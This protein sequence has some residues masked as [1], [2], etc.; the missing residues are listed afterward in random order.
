MMP[1]AFCAVI[2]GGCIAQTITISGR[3]KDTSGEGISGALVKLEQANISTTTGADGSFTLTG[4]AAIG[5]SGGSYKPSDGYMIRLSGMSLL[6]TFKERSNVLIEIFHTN[7]R[8]IL[9][10]RRMGNAGNHV[11]PLPQLSPGIYLIRITLGTDRYCFTGIPLNRPIFHSKWSRGISHSGGLSDR[12]A[13]VS[14]HFDDVL[15]VT[16]EGLLTHRIAVRN[17]DARG[18]DITMLHNAGDVADA[19]GN[20][21]QSVRIGNQVW[22]AENLKTTK[23]NDGTAITTVPDSATW[24]NIYLNALT[25]DA[26]CVYGGGAA[27]GAKYGV[28]YNWYAVGTGK[29]APKGWRVPTDTDWDTLQNYLIAHGYNYDGTTTGNQIAKSMAA[30]WGWDSSTIEGAVGNDLSTNNASGFSALPGGLRHWGGGYYSLFLERKLTYW[31]SSTE[32]DSVRAWHRWL[33]YHQSYL[34][35]IFHHKNTG[36]AVRIIRDVH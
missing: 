27:S 21:Y 5:A 19:D 9:A 35:R 34:D 33:D 8:S 29:L 1:M 3:V 24:L 25:T 7:G 32:Y 17:P 28:F 20:V 12:E 22:A 10:D 30:Q 11:V 4:E 36:F 16:K 14:A 15:V 2:S 6:I 31:W 18:I 13:N 23:Y 26:Y